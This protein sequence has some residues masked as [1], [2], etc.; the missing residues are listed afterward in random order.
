MS[1]DTQSP[2]GGRDLL[3]TA[4]LQSRLV[5]ELGDEYRY[6][7]RALQQMAARDQ[8]PMPV[9]VRHGEQGRRGHLFDWDAVLE[10]LEAESSRQDTAGAD[11]V[12]TLSGGILVTIRAMSAELGMDYYTLARRLESWN[13]EPVKYRKGTGPAAGLY[14]VGAIFAALTASARA[15]DPDA[16]PAVERDA[17]YR[18]ELR[19]DELRRQ[20]RELIEVDDARRVLG[21]LVQL[22]AHDYDLIPDILEH[23]ANLGP[24]ALDAVQQYLDEAREERA[25]SIV[26]LEAQLTAPPIEDV[27]RAEVRSAQRQDKTPTGSA[28]TPP[29]DFHPPA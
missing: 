29:A 9:A 16:L 7:A 18:S 2:G 10:W 25:R 3:T 5:A 12:S 19:K 23:K 24:A 11:V 13:V 27:Q 15:E 20:R 1:D 6:T 17:Y 4:Q 28:A 26:D 22:L 21:A 8:H 14:S